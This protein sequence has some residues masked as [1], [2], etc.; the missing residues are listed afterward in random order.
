MSGDYKGVTFDTIHTSSYNMILSKKS[1]ESPVPKTETVDIPGGD[2]VLDMTE[3]FGDVKYKNRKI[4]LVFSINLTGP[5]L[6]DTY[7][8]ILNDLH[9]KHFEKIILDDDPDYYYT[10]RVT[11]VTLAEG[12]INKLTVECSCEPYK[13]GNKLKEYSLLIKASGSETIDFGRKN[14]AVSI[15]APF[16]SWTLKID[17]IEYGVYKI[18]DIEIV[19]SGTHKITITANVIGYQAFIRFPETKL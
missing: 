13:T 3:Y 11:A 15:N 18:P 10:G 1:I 5:E 7:S 17:D 12:E 16:D 8:D 9:G 19:I 4:T 2:G 6:L 14:I